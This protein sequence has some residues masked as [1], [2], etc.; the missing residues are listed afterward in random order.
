MK[1][2]GSRLYYG[3]E[4]MKSIV[5]LWS[6]CLLLVAGPASGAACENWN[7]EEFFQTAT[8]KAVTTCLEAGSDSNARDKDGVTPLH[9]AAAF[10]ENPAVITILLHAGAGLNVRS[11]NGYTPLHAAGYNETPAIITPLLEAGAD[12]NTRDEAGMT[13]LH[14]AAGH[15]NNPSVITALLNAGAD[16]NGAEQKWPHPPACGGRVQRK[17][18]HYHGLVGRWGGC[19]G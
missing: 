5:A 6:L 17:P 15:N 11:Q 1:R 13:P 19:Q 16:L 10:N 4:C 7:T 9:W 2:I 12:L 3:S 14:H 18:R 8:P